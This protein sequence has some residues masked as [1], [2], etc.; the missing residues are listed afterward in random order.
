MS[1]AYAPTLYRYGLN[2]WYGFALPVSAAM[3]V[4][5]TVDSALRHWV[6]RSGEWKGRTHAR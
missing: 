3:Y 5:M 1:W 2:S 4:L 6:G